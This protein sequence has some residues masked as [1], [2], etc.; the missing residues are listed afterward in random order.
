MNPVLLLTDLFVFALLAGAV[1]YLR[2]VR[3][4]P[5]LRANWRLALQ[6]PAAAV[7]AVILG[8]FLL[9]ALADSL[10]YRRA[11]PPFSSFI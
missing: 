1:L 11:G 9:V 10:H 8:L 7:S 3:R 2:H 6:R 5:Q 4:S